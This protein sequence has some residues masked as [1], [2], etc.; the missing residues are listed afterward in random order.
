MTVIDK[1]RGRLIVSCQ[2][3]PQ[4]PLH[5]PIF[6]AAMAKAAALGGAGGIRANGEADIAAIRAVVTLPILGIRKRKVAGTEIYIT[7][8]FIDAQ[9]VVRAGADLVALDGTIRPRSQSEPS[10][11][12]LIARIHD[13]LRVPVMADCSC[14]ADA[15]AAAAA[16]ADLLATTLSGYTDHG[17]PPCEGPDLDLID[18]LVE[19]FSLPVIAEGRFYRPEQV[20][21]AFD[22]GAFAVVVGGAITRPHEITCRFVEAIPASR[23]RDADRSP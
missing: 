8:E 5:G 22:R 16:G 14:V 4:E 18:A 17:R 13:E 10:L 12:N 3:L 6:M 23:V 9:A 15:E 19:R 1:L 2:A 21:E 11:P 20:A 7:P